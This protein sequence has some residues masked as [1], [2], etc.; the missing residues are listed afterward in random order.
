MCPPGSQRALPEPKPG[1][2]AAGTTPEPLS[3]GRRPKP[4]TPH[5]RPVCG[6]QLWEPA[7]R[8]RPSRPLEAEVPALASM[9]PSP[10]GIL[11]VEL[12]CS[13]LQPE[14]YESFPPVGRVVIRGN[15]E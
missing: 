13:L 8:L 3:Q 15:G 5:N 12:G 11:G 2:P 7:R 4:P 6:Q 10:A 1:P 14:T 9:L